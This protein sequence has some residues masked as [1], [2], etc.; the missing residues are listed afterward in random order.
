MAPGHLTTARSS[1]ICV[2]ACL[3]V[4]ARLLWVCT[5]L[6]FEWRCRKDHHLGV[7]QKQEGLRRFWS[8]FPLSRVPFWYRFFEPLPSVSPLEPRFW[9]DPSHELRSR[10]RCVQKA[11]AANRRYEERMGGSLGEIGC[12][13]WVGGLKSAALQKWRNKRASN[14]YTPARSAC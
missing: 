9:P 7:A 13:G 1:S 8:M 11:T 5:F 3:R 10:Q 2:R 4:S 12:G 14:K 6:W